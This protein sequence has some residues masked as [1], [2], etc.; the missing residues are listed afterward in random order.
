MGSADQTL[1]LEGPSHLHLNWSR[2]QCGQL[3]SAMIATA[4]GAQYEPTT[5]DFL[6]P[7]WWPRW[8]RIT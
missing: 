8:G 2:V 3:A 1:Q 6:R 7:Y 5:V 4:A